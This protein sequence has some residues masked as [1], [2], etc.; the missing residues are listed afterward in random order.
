MATTLK[1][2]D[3]D[4]DEVIELLENAGILFDYTGH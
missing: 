3:E 4:I 2:D 1:F